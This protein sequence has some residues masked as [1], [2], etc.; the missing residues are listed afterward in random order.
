MNILFFAK[1]KIS[2]VKTITTLHYNEQRREAKTIVYLFI[3]ITCV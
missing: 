2:E 1:I 3:I